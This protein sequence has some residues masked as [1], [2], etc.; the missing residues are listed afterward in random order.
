[1]LER[2]GEQL[3]NNLVFFV[4]GCFRSRNLSSLF[5]F[6]PLVDQKRDVA[7]VIDDLV[8][9]GAVSE[10]ESPLGAPP[11]FFE[12]LPFPCENGD[13]LRSGNGSVLAD[14]DRRGGVILRAEDVAR[15]PAHLGAE[16]GQRFD[17]HGGLDRHVQRPDDLQ[18]SQRLAGSILIPHG[19]QPGH[20][21]L[22]KHDLFA[23]PFGIRQVGYFEFKPALS[24]RG[25]RFWPFGRQC[26]H[27]QLLL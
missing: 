27:D 5:E 8:R 7:A 19:H 10:I 3:E 20:L 24:G 11:I 2:L 9:T 1:M 17:E 18:P 12:R 13:A 14:G 15:T 4:V 21:L 25:G 26:T 23:S 22:G 6:G 16:R